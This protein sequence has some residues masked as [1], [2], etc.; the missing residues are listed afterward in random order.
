MITD[1]TFYMAAIP[2]VFFVGVSKGGLGA[3][4]PFGMP[5][6]AMVISP[7]QGAAI[8]LPIL[9]VMDAVAIRSYW[10]VFDRQVLQDMLPSA[11][12]G[13]CVGWA[14]AAFVDEIML[15]LLIGIM[16]LA[17]TLHYFL[18]TNSKTPSPRNRVKAVFAG[19]VAG[20]TSFVTHAGGPPFQVYTLPLKL[21]RRIFAG[22]SVLFFAIVNVIKLVPYFALGQFDSVNL[23]TSAVLMPLAVASTMIGVWLV[24]RVSQVLF[25]RIM[26]FGLLLV[27]I[28]LIWDGLSDLRIL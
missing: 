18:W 11:I 13:I 4:A 2:A 24:K 8:M 12:V 7:I 22:T 3:I 6:L 16:A 26:Y 17:F 9:L 14:T 19:L 27:S 20:Y 10:G 23:M 1:I 15:K 21:D 5:F 25:Y 28:K